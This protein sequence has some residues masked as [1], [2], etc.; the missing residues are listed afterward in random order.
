MNS[1]AQH[2]KAI[3]GFVVPGVVTL[4]SAVAPSSGGGTRITSTEWITAMLACV[5]TSGAVYAKSNAAPP[6]PCAVCGG[7]GVAPTPVVVAPVAPLAPVVVAPVLPVVINV[8][9]PLPPAA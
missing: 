8:A 4:A 5:L 2:W 3:L 6:I 9:P 1:F 7:S